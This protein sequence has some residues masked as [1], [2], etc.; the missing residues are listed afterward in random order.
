MINISISTESG[1]SKTTCHS[2]SKKI[3]ERRSSPE[4]KV[5]KDL[6]NVRL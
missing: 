2:M 1:K 3:T 5:R 6:K 4:Y